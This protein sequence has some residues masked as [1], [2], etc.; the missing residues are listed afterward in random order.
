[1]FYRYKRK[2][3]LTSRSILQRKDVEAFLVP[4]SA[5]FSFLAYPICKLRDLE[6]VES[7]HW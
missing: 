5:S 2:V 4:L 7:T 3:G 6:L 1:V